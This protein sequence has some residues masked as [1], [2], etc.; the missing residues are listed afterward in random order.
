ME[1]EDD[2][3]LPCGHT[4]CWIKAFGNP[5]GGIEYFCLRCLFEGEKEIVKDGKGDWVYKV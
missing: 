3:D 2:R 5:K 4:E 1:A